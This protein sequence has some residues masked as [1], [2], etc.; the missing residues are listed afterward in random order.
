MFLNAT[1]KLKMH[2]HL[3]SVFKTKPPTNNIRTTQDMRHKQLV[4]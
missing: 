2:Q 3:L 4:Y 1:T